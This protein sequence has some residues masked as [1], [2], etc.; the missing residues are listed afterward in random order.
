MEKDLFLDGGQ[1]LS[2]IRGAAAAA[3]SSMRALTAALMR[4]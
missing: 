3:S 2:Y 4:I 1:Q